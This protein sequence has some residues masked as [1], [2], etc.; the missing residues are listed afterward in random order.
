[1][2]RWV[3]VF[4]IAVALLTQPRVTQAQSLTSAEVYV[5]IE[6][7]V[8]RLTNEGMRRR[9]AL[10]RWPEY[11]RTADYALDAETGR[12][13]AEVYRRYHTSPGAHLAFGNRQVQ[14]IRRYLKSHP[15]L[16]GE[17][18]LLRSEFKQLSSAL[19]HAMPAKPTAQPAQAKPEGSAP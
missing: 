9:L 10:L 4:G 11:T 16:Q 15:E 1:M 5:R 6:L 7:S 13:V 19:K 12:A 3:V 17:Q 2:I 14:A 18:E 8:R